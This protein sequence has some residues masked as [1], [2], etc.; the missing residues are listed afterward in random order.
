M[1]GGDEMNKRLNV[2]LDDKLKKEFKLR[3]VQEGK[4]ITQKVWELIDEYLK[5]S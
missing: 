5:H 2:E 4:T 3:C 1:K